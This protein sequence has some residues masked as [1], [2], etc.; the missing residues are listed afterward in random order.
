MAIKDRYASGSMPNDA[1]IALLDDRLSEVPSAESKGSGGVHVVQERSNRQD[2][3][4]AI[5]HTQLLKDG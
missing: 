3:L 4:T 1:Q 2:R 5:V